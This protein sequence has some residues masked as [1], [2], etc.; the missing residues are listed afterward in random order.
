MLLA[1]VHKFATGSKLQHGRHVNVGC[2]IDLLS[3]CLCFCLAASRPAGPGPGPNRRPDRP[4]LTCVH[5]LAAMEP[6][7]ELE[8][9]LWLQMEM[10]MELESWGAAKRIQGVVALLALKPWSV[11][12]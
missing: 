10:E 7:P 9:E 11:F 8:L 4:V 3:I 2:R 1:Q 12:C 5:L 6:E